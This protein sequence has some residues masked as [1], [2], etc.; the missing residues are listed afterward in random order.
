MNRNQQITDQK[1]RT[2]WV[3]D[4]VSR[5][6][7][8]EEAGRTFDAW[9]SSRHSA[10]VAFLGGSLDLFIG[11]A[12]QKAAEAAKA[13]EHTSWAIRSA[14]LG[15]AEAYRDEHGPESRVLVMADDSNEDLLMQRISR[16]V[17]AY[18]YDPSDAEKI[19]SAMKGQVE[20]R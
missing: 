19:R 10:V 7:D 17:D 1:L 18:G 5:G 12:Q 16:V 14:V 3:N 2:L 11:D 9:V 15:A 13:G 20:A 8:A 4:A 6:E